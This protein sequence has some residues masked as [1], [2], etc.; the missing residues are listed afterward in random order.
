MLAEDGRQLQEDPGGAVD[1]GGGDDEKGMAME[2][3]GDE[4]TESEP[5]QP[6]RRQRKANKAK[7]LKE[8]KEVYTNCLIV[9]IKKTYLVFFYNSNGH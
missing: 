6:T 3:G 2:M 8:A 1:H 5:L 7:A 9:L 4:A